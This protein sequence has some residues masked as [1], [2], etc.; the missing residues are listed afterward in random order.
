MGSILEFAHASCPP[1]PTA[2]F[3]LIALPTLLKRTKGIKWHLKGSW[4]RM[5]LAKILVPSPFH[6]KPSESGCCKSRGA[7]K[8]TWTLGLRAAMGVGNP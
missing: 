8:V 3:I 2:H 7:S 5:Q 4:R 6:H 1:P